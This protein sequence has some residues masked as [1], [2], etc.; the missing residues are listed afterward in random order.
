MDWPAS[1][2]DIGVVERQNRHK[3]RQKTRRIARYDKS[4]GLVREQ[5]EVKS[6]RPYIL[7][8]PILDYGAD[9]PATLGKVNASVDASRKGKERERWEWKY[10]TAERDEERESRHISIRLGSGPGS[11][12]R[13]FYQAT[14]FEPIRLPGYFRR[15][16]N[17]LLLL[18]N[19]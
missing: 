19:L 16:G 14:R 9:G 4:A 10:A 18:F 15:P 12:S 8:G 11:E 6:R 3:G 5:R 17:R 7:A 13:R 2:T 1:T